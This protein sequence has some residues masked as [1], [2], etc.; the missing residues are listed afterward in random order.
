MCLCYSNHNIPDDMKILT[1][2]D[3]EN[4]LDVDHLSNIYGYIIRFLERNNITYREWDFISHLLIHGIDG[5]SSNR[6]KRHYDLDGSDKP[7]FSENDL[8]KY[9]NIIPSGEYPIF[10][11]DDK[12][13]Y[14]IDESPEGEK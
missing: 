5:S 1:G 8:I 11:E 9:D 13:I 12:I 7:N 10:P 2:Y 14:T 3:L 4:V 6:C